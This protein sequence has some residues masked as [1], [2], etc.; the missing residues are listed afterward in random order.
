MKDHDFYCTEKPQ[1]CKYC[2]IQLGG[3]KLAEHEDYCGSKS[4]KCT[5]CQSSVTLKEWDMHKPSGACG[6]TREINQGKAIR[7][8]E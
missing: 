6:F 4:R 5:E 7:E 2:E 3:Q 8:L 1:Q